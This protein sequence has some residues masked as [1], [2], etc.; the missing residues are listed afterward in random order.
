MIISID[1]SH[2][3]FSCEDYKNDIV[4]FQLMELIKQFPMLLVSNEKD[5]IIG[6]TSRQMPIWVWTSDDLAESSKTELCDYFYKQF[7]DYKSFKKESVLFCHQ[8]K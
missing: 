2:P 5:F 8:R 3:I 4:P 6:M 7:N 1:K